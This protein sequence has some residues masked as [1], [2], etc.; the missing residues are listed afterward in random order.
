MKAYLK[1][2]KFG[3]ALFVMLTGLAG[4]AVAFPLGQ[5]PELWRAFLLVIGL[6]LV[7]SGS[8]AI[9][10]AQEWRVDKEMP[11]TSKRPVASGLIEAWQAYFLGFTFCL[12]GTFLLTLVEVQTGL[13][14]LSTVLLY[15]GLYTLYWK[16]QWAFGAVPGAIPGAMPVV[17]GYSAT[18]QG[19]A[20]QEC[21]YM[22]LIMFLW[23]MPHFWALAIRYSDE[24]KRA[25]FPV[26]PAQLG[27]DRTL[28]HIG[29]YTFAYVGVALAAPI[30]VNT[31]VGFVLLVLP[32]A[33]KVIWEFF[34]YYKARAQKQWLPFFLWVNFSMLA[35]LSVPVFDKWFFYLLAVNGY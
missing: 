10:Q 19:F 30:F 29:L 28:Y 25:G 9:N 20:T 33:L 7:S 8:F 16:K 5:Q 34:K 1:L 3:I 24:Y 27:V 13:L 12:I 22:F 32:F 31:H 2:T 6:Y 17:I 26:L 18:G 23:Q 35:F 11:R 4:Y 15:N 21:F 14:A